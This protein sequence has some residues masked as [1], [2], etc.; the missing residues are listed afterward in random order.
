MIAT[1]VSN[2]Y[3]TSIFLF[4]ILIFFPDMNIDVHIISANRNMVLHIWAFFAFFASMFSF[5]WDIRMDWGLLTAN[6]DSAQYPLRNV[7]LF[8]PWV[9]SHLIN[10]FSMLNYQKHMSRSE[11]LCFQHS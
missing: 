7:T 11:F 1:F 9:C 6:K 4:L 2:I 10:F 8:S 5:G 3:G